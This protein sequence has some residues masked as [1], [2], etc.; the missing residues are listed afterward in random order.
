MQKGI[1]D[2]FIEALVERMRGFRI[3]PGLDRTVT[4]GPLI[5]RAAVDEV[6][7]HIDDAVAKGA[8]LVYEGKVRSDLGGHFIEPALVTGVTTEMAVAREETFGPLAPVFRFDTVDGC[9]QLANDTEFG[10]AGYFF[11][12]DLKTIWNV[13]RRLGV[14]M[15]GVNTG[16]ISAAEA[17]FGGVKESGLGREGSKYGLAEFQVIKNIPLRI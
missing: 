2:R 5:N 9:L 3:G 13:A 8:E 1:H 6:K 10:L 12:G 7:F 16:K 14:G 4:H 11:S 17:P 15:I